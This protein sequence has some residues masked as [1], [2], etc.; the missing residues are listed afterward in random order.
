MKDLEA[1]V[2]KKIGKHRAATHL[3]LWKVFDYLDKKLENLD[4]TGTVVSVLTLDGHGKV[5]CYGKRIEESVIFDQLNLTSGTHGPKVTGTVSYP[6]IHRLTS[7]EKGYFVSGVEFGLGVR[8]YVALVNIPL[9]PVDD[10]A[11]K[12][13]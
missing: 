5:N 10:Q 6:A 13:I 12:Y 4:I 7:Y 3:E 8:D 1:L 11:R 2:K 9:S